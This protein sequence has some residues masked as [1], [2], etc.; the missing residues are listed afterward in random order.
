MD[1]RIVVR[2]GMLVA[3]A[4]SEVPRLLNAVLVLA[5]HTVPEERVMNGSAAGW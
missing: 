1:S 5:K 2:P 4:V 3:V